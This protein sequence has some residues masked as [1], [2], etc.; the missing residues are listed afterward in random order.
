M[1]ENGP[2]QAEQQGADK[3]GMQR[4]GDLRLFSFADILGDE[5]ICAHSQTGG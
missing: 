1:P 2:Q 4:T 5:D 3:R